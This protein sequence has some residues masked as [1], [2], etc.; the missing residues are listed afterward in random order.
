MTFYTPL[1]HNAYNFQNN[2]KIHSLLYLA[3]KMEWLFYLYL[4]I[5]NNMFVTN[6]KGI[7]YITDINHC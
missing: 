4:S 6:L 5:L 1:Y 7:L 3:F 2:F